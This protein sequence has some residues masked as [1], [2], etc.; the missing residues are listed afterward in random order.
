MSVSGGTFNLVRETEME[1][2]V[3]EKGQNTVSAVEVQEQEVCVTGTQRGLALE[4]RAVGACGC[5]LTPSFL[6]PLVLGLPS[7]ESV[8]YLQTRTDSEAALISLLVA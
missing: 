5:F 1:R 2:A 8:W 3:S 6:Y 4:D 7:L